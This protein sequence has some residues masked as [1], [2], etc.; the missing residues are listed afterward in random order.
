MES[1]TPPQGCEEVSQAILSRPLLRSWRGCT[2]SQTFGF[3][4]YEYDIANGQQF[5]LTNKK[6]LFKLLS[7][8]RSGKVLGVMI[9]MLCTS[10]SVPGIE[11]PSYVPVITHG[12]Y[13]S[14]IFLNV[15]LKKF[16]S[17]IFV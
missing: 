10:F 7:A 11:P 14:I 5:D 15:T 4:V 12:G 13:L 16:A 6:V 17:A 1:A 2:C 8:I 3:S 9:A